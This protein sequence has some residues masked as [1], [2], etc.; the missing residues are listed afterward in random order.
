MGANVF[1]WTI[2]N[3]PC[4]P[5]SSQVTLTGVVSPTV[6]NAGTDAT[7]CSSSSIL[8]GNIATSGKGL[9]TLISGSGIISTP[10]SANSTV[11]G[12]GI[13]SNVFQWT[14]SN[15]PCPPSSD[16]VTITNTG[17]GPAVTISSQSNVSCYGGN[18]GSASASVTG[19]GA[20]YHIHGQQVAEMLQQQTT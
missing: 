14:I 8:G 1:Q 5:S 9:W 7:I 16:Q 6:S 2:S 19:G 13:G 10:S 18:N 12:L 17:S 15:A 11:T 20:I 3:A 4:A